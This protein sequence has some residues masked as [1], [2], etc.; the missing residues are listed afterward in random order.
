MTQ[1]NPSP[2][3]S[4]LYEK[5]AKISANLEKSTPKFNGAMPVTPRVHN[6]Q[7][8]TQQATPWGKKS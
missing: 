6:T 3:T 8:A 4:A 2:S 1:Q 5:I 7:P